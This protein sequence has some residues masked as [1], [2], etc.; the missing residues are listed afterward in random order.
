[1]AEDDLVD[2]GNNTIIDSITHPKSAE[3]IEDFE[4]CQHIH[5]SRRTTVEGVASI[6]ER[7]SLKFQNH[8]REL[9]RQSRIMD[10]EI[11]KYS[12]SKQEKLIILGLRPKG[13][14]IANLDRYKLD[15]E[16]L[17]HR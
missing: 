13:L 8:I 15:L 3:T 10:E 11:L 16:K 2:P 14:H 1:M 9:G 5:K 7:K 4:K 17:E 6:L 12:Q